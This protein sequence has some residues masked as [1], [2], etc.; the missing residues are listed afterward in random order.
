MTKTKIPV[1]EL[2]EPTWADDMDPRME[3]RRVEVRQEHARGRRRV[4]LV[5]IAI[6]GIGS[7]TWA[8]TRTPLLAVEHARVTGID[9]TTVSDVVRAAHLER[10]TPMTDIDEHGAARRLEALPWVGSA[11][12]RREWPRTVQVEIR[13]RTATAAATAAGGGWVLLDG[14]G[15]VLA[16]LGTPPADQPLL[17]GVPPAG[18]PGSRLARAGRPALAVAAALAPELRSRVVVISAQPDGEV[19]LRVRPEGIVRL[20]RSERMAEKLAALRTMV[21]RADL[22]RLAVLDLRVPTNP[23]LTRQ[24]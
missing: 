6:I 21:A 10:G 7:A 5:L 23:V 19:E 24:P 12:V 15:R 2:A 1:E 13:E 17:D 20:G 11:R 9:A 22:R 18:A 14:T 3:Q 16:N 8:V 4:V